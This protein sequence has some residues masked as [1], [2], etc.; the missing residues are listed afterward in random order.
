MN[1]RKKKLSDKYGWI[2]KSTNCSSASR[3]F[4]SYYHVWWGAT[5]SHDNS[6]SLSFHAECHPVSL[7]DLWRADLVSWSRVIFKQCNHI[8]VF[9]FVSI[10]VCRLFFQ[11]A[12]L[13]W[14][15]VSAG[16]II[17]TK[18][19]EVHRHVKRVKTADCTTVCH[20]LSLCTNAIF[21]KRHILFSLILFLC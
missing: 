13:T 12:Q 3:Y 8:L 11:V 5:H 20:T 15:I 19:L 1:R 18:T 9:V 17:N 16:V 2:C 7:E 10:P 21:R 14:G 4:V 6:S